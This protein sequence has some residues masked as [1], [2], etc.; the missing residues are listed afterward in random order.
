MSSHSALLSIE[1]PTVYAGKE[2]GKIKHQLPIEVRLKAC[3]SV[4]K[5]YLSKAY[6]DLN[7]TV[8]LVIRI[9]TEYGFEE[10]F[11][12]MKRTNLYWR[13]LVYDQI[14]RISPNLTL[15]S[16]A[17]NEDGAL[18]RCAAEAWPD[19]PHPVLGQSLNE[20]VKSVH[21]FG[22]VEF[23]AQGKEIL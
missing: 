2:L 20:L 18:L 15:P 17:L 10:L 22:D 5:R 9:E 6:Q 7:S 21:S 23:H 19:Y 16:P 8:F 4:Y 13:I 1:L 11:D 12:E 3:S 14:V